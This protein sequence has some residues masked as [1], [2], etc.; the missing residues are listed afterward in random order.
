M[1]VSARCWWPAAGKNKLKKF[2]GS[3]FQERTAFL[4][5]SSKKLFMIRLP[6]AVIIHSREHAAAALVPDLP[7]TLLSAPG[8]ALYGGCGWWQALLEQAGYDG[9]ALLDC[10]DAPGRA[11]EAVRLGLFGVVLAAEPLIF[12]RVQ[13]IAAGTRTILLEAAPPAL[14]LAKANARR[15][16]TAWLEDR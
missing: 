4:K 8:F 12:A 9:P 3:F 13:G 10:G 7:V 16:L 11:V 6:P 5:K 15:L 1:S 2:F 14:D